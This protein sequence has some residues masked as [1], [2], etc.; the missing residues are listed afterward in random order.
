MFNL[1]H[2]SAPMFMRGNALVFE[3]HLSKM[4]REPVLKNTCHGPR[5]SLPQR[6]FPYSF[7]LGNYE[8]RYELT[9][10]WEG[11]SGGRHHK[12]FPRGGLHTRARVAGCVGGRLTGLIFVCARTNKRHHH[13]QP[14]W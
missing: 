1:P 13:H 3:K 8:L 2:T 11:L 14:S 12:E 7:E 6:A 10:N 5:T 4:P 9:A